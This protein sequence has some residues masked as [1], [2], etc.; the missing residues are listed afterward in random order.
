MRTKLI[1]FRPAKP[2]S[3]SLTYIPDLEGNVAKRKGTDIVK[4]DFFSESVIRFSNLQISKKN[5]PKNYPEL[6]I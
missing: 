2:K 6:E 1:T 5:I 3:C 4:G